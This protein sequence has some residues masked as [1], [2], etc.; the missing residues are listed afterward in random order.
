MK[1]VLLL[2]TLALM[3]AAAMALSGV[4]QAKPI[5]N[6]KADAKCL[7][8]AIRTLPSGFNPSD[9]TFYGGPGVDLIFSNED[10]FF[11][12]EGND[13]VQINQGTFYGGE[14]I[15]TV[16]TGTP[17]KTDHRRVTVRSGTATRA[18]T[19]TSPGPN[20]G[21]GVRVRLRP[22]SPTP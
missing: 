10:T 3:F 20:A 7:V 14:G 11:G 4:A 1:R 5:T 17:P 16:G 18:G 15:D 21:F 9:Y 13:F 6:G 2:V 22:R 12:G 19:A 8:E